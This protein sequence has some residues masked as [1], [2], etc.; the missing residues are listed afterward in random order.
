MQ[1]SHFRSLALCWFKIL[2][3]L[4]KCLICVSYWV[5]NIRPSPQADQRVVRET[6]TWTRNVRSW[7]CRHW[8]SRTSLRAQIVARRADISAGVEAGKM[9]SCR[10]NEGLSPDSWKGRE[11]VLWE[12]ERG[13]KCVCVSY[14]L[15]VSGP[16]RQRSCHEE[17][18]ALTHSYSAAVGGHWSI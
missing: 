18:L 2:F 17:L 15:L 9:W 8:W 5:N 3:H 12:E 14:K 10:L 1:K 7:G 11:S 4:Q 16:W 13:I 6:D